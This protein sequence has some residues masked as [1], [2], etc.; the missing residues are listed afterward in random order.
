MDRKNGQVINTILIV[1][2]GGILIYTIA[3]EEP[4]KYLQIAGF[5]LIMLGLYRAT[6]YWVETK[7]DHKIEKEQQ[8]KENEI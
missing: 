1:V 4:Q 3:I 8:E 2:G 6:N 7:D 5:I